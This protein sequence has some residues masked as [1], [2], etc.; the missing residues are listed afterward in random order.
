MDGKQTEKYLGNLYATERRHAILDSPVNWRINKNSCHRGYELHKHSI[1]IHNLSHQF[2]Q[3]SS[4][5]NSSTILQKLSSN[6]FRYFF[7]L[8]NIKIVIYAMK[9]AP[10][11]KIHIINFILA[12]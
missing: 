11:T 8:S 3:F 2:R 7:S 12:M 6:I 10:Q 5:S 1:K 9:N 4:L